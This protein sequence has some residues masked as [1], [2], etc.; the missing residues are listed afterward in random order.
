MI[1]P[2]SKN[3][4]EQITAL[5]KENAEWKMTVDGHT[6]NVGGETFNQ[7]LSD[8]RA[9]AVK[10]YFIKSGIGA[11]RLQAVGKGLAAPVAS[12]ENEIG[13]AQNRR[14]ELVKN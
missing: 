8:K 14:V 4:L 7:N 13:K 9:K 2:E 3:V 6:D 1:R 10:D 5:L 11:E 12:N